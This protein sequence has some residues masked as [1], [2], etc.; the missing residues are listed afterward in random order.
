M[1]KIRVYDPPMCCPT[2]VCGP[3]IDPSLARFA[4]DLDWLRRRG[5]EV[6][7]F[8]LAQE[9]GAFAASPEVLEAM[10]RLG[11]A[12]LPMILVEGRVPLH[13]SYPGRAE[14]AE[15]TGLE[16]EAE[17]AGGSTAGGASSGLFVLGDGPGSSGG[18]C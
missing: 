9:P 2:G 4:A 5:V 3:G 10:E 6:E 12:A 7:R 13:G 16:R 14:L 18:C 15:M 11:D 17:P 1:S 8:N